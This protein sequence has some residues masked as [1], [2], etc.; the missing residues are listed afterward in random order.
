MKKLLL[1][2]L[3]RFGAS[4]CIAMAAMAGMTGEAQALSCPSGKVADGG[5]CYSPPRAGYSCT[6]AACMED[7]RSGYSPSVPGFCHY[8]GSLTYTEKAYGK[9]HK[10]TPHKCLLL[11]YANCRADY[12]MDACGI[13]T[14][15]GAWDT[16]RHTYFREPGISADFSQAFNH[17]GSTMQATY[18]SSIGA[19]Q[20]A[21]YAAM[22]EI[23]K[24]IDALTLRLFHEAAK[25]AMAKDLGKSLNKTFVAFKNAKSNADTLNDMKR[26]LAIVA[27]K[28]QLAD[29][30]AEVKDIANV[31]LKNAG[32]FGLLCGTGMYEAFS[33][34]LTSNFPSNLQNSS[35]GIFAAIGSA[36][37]AGADES[38]GLIH[39]CQLDSNGRMQFAVV[40]TVGG[41]LGAA[42]IAGGDIGFMWNPGAVG[43][44]GGAYVGMAGAGDIGV[45]VAGTVSWSVAKGMRGAQNAIP[46]FSAA[47]GVGV[48]AQLSLI[49]G[50]ATILQTFSYKP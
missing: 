44:Q 41:S 46:G 10:S 25:L 8:R 27:S 20:S 48:G 11:Y 3:R 16:T 29:D 37:V 6:G 38:I 7:C 2:T 40:S 13:C 50:N 45:G 42:L 21:Y 24:G 33:P 23:Q 28:K 47:T 39:N 19:M 30:S 22:A 12:H 5:L 1:K 14:Y 4:A 31:M 49:G 26:V 35:S 34:G 36:V 9:H 17:I 15:K 43:K 18:G 32:K